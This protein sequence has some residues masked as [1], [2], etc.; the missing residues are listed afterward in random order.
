[1][2]RTLFKQCDLERALRAV[3]AVGADVGVRIERLTGDILIGSVN[4]APDEIDP[5][6]TGAMWDKFNAA[7]P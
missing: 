1:M 3:A 5:E 7:R 4:A 2:A 6:D